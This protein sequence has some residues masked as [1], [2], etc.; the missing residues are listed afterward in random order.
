MFYHQQ[1]T[2]SKKTLQ[3]I[4]TLVL[5]LRFHLIKLKQ[6]LNKIKQASSNN[7]ISRSSNSTLNS[8]SSS[9]SSTS[10]SSDFN[11]DAPTATTP[12]SNTSL[13]PAQT[14]KPVQSPHPPKQSPSKSTNSNKI[15]HTSQMFSGPPQ[16]S[17][18]P[19]GRVYA[20][21]LAKTLAEQKNIKLQGKGSGMYDSITSKDVDKLAASAPVQ[22][23]VPASTA[24]KAK[25]TTAAPSPAAVIP[26]GAAYVDIPVTNIRATIA[27]R[28]L[29]SKTRVPHY[30]LTIHCRV[31][32]LLA[33]RDKF[34][35]N[36]EKEKL[37]LSVND[38]IIKACAMA[39]KKVPEANSYWMDN[40]IR[41]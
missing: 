34:N 13:A 15:L 35:K 25:A 36:L 11:S 37:K 33:I 6:Q 17:A 30:Y 29:E 18:P 12:P 39:C 31:D 7:D 20:S 3:I 22:P 26:P 8:A 41:Q 38:F 9:T 23:T 27:K 19:S 4:Y 32:K 40:V 28:L 10:V 24:P 16:T 5:A 1:R 21:P 2:F 14:T